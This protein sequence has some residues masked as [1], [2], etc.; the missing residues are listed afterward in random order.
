MINRKVTPTESAADSK[1]RGFTKYLAWNAYIKDTGLKPEVD[2]SEFY[3]LFEAI[4]PELMLKKTIPDGWTPTHFDT[5]LSRM[6]QVTLRDGF[7]ELVW[8]GGHTGSYPMEYFDESRYL[9]V[10]E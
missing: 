9:E 4:T 5:F 10:T 1:A 7:V 6:V 2:A 8:D 3:R